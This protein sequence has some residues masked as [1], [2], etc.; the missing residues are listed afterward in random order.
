MKKI[1]DW[2]V[3]TSR[4]FPLNFAAKTG[5]GTKGE[6]NRGG[7]RKRPGQQENGEEKERQLRKGGASPFLTQAQTLGKVL[8]RV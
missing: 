3:R 6:Y 2:L 1:K 5:K 4:S 7:K 8:F